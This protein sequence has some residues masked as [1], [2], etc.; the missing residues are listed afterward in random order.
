MVKWLLRTGG[1]LTQQTQ[2]TEEKSRHSTAVWSA[3]AILSIY[4]QSELVILFW[5]LS[6][7][8]RRHKY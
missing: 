3:S 8:Y 2:V 5:T 1:E 4:C 6:V 7:T